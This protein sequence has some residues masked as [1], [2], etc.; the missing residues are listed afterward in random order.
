MQKKSINQIRK[1]SEKERVIS[2]AR[3]QSR[4][5]APSNRRLICRKS[6]KNTLEIGKRSAKQMPITKAK[7]KTAKY[8]RPRK[9]FL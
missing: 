9:V 4:K 8:L 2:P 6:V 1:K 5:R 3:E 7:V